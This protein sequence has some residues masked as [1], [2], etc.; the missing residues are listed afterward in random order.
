M[1]WERW[2]SRVY[3]AA[4]L[5]RDESICGEGA[6]ERA[7]AIQQAVCVDLCL[8]LSVCPTLS[9]IIRNHPPL[10][11]HKTSALKT[12]THLSLEMIIVLLFCEI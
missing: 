1:P 2:I 10:N 12:E 6:S 11:K 5:L 8:F 9:H 7:L 3:P 4:H